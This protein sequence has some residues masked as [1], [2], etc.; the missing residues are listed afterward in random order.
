[1]QKIRMLLILILTLACPHLTL[2]NASLNIPILCYHNF[3]P[4][5][6]GSMNLTPQKFESQIQWLKDNGY[7][8]ISLKDAVE[9][10][11]DK[12]ATL[13]AKSI[14]VTMDDGW[15]S[16]YTYIYPIAKKYNIP[17]TLFIYPQTISQ[18]K[19]AMTWDQLKELK[20]TGLFDIQGHTYWHPNFKQEKK[21][22]SDAS[23]DKFVKEQLVASKRVLE[24]KLGTKITLLAWPFGI[25]NP[26]LEQA[27]A[28]AGYDMSFTIDAL[29]A[30]RSHRAMAQPRYMI[31]DAQSMKTFAGIAHTASDKVQTVSK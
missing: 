6:P 7:T 30:N 5:T 8:I 22:R 17:V 13:P 26:Y 29:P 4:T 14:V 19:N 21:K 15:K 10:L 9:Y 24:E 3:S 23:Y 2:A 28:S 1:M 18:G 12:R 31:I 20:N 27:A 11:Q 25:Y 16:V